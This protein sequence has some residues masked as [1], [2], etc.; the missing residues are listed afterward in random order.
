V[1]GAAV[2]SR[3]HCVTDW[4]YFILQPKA[5]LS[6]LSIFIFQRQSFWTHR[7]TYSNVLCTTQ[8]RCIQLCL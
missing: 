6:T 1:P 3:A 4:F 7:P 8:Y 2:L 5:G